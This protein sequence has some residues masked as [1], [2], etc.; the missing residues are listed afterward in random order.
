MGAQAGQLTESEVRPI[1]KKDS[2]LWHLQSRMV[3]I[4]QQLPSRKVAQGS[5]LVVS[6]PKTRDHL[7]AKGHQL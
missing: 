5:Q 2:V 1:L 6:R 4:V 7:E 3:A